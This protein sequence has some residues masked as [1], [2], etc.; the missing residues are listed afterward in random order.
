MAQ[1]RTGTSLI[2]GRMDRFECKSTNQPFSDDWVL[3]P[4][5]KSDQMY[6]AAGISPSDAV[7]LSTDNEAQ[8]GHTT[9]MQCLR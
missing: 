8:L 4:K 9:K 5:L 6:S 7:R 3:Q 1:E 2:I